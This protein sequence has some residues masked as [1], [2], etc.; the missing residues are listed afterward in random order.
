MYHTCINYNTN[1]RALYYHSA[2]K[3]YVFALNIVFRS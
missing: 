2:H 1:A 3:S